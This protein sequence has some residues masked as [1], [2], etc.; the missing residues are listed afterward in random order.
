LQESGLIEIAI[1]TRIKAD[2]FGKNQ[3]SPIWGKI[4]S[5]PCLTMPTIGRWDISYWD[6][7]VYADKLDT[8]LQNLIQSCI[9]NNIKQLCDID[10]LIGHIKDKRDVFVTNDKDHFIKRRDCLQK[11]CGVK[12]MTPEEC[13]EYFFQNGL[14]N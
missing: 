13:I 2:T 10:H 14:T 4:K 8:D 1:T 3:D 9:G 12:I 7:D 6:E 11:K 5:F